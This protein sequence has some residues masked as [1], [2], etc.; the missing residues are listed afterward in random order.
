[1][2]RI[3]KLIACDLDGTLL[4]SH[5]LIPPRAADGIRAAL[6]PGVEFTFSSGRGEESMKP[7][8]AQMGI[9]HVPMITE[10]GALLQ[11][12]VDW[13]IIAEWPLSAKV[14]AH[15]LELLEQGPYDFNFYL[16]HSG[17]LVVFKNAAAPFFLAGTPYGIYD[18]LFREIHTWHGQVF[19]GFRKIAIRCHLEETEALKN[20]LEQGLGATATVKKSAANCIDVMGTGVTKGSALVTLAHML[21]VDMKNVMAIGDNETD[22]SMFSVA[23]VPVT[24]A[25]GDASAVQLARYVV[26]SNDECGVVT[27]VERFVTGEYHA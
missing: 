16:S 23:G 19:D 13:H 21:Q 5:S 10:T 25:N 14:V 6:R 27:A 1:M 22:A 18:P 24:T 9:I 4:D 20:L 11:D 8:V 15:V 7:F 2:K 3:E 17:E 26:P 12:P